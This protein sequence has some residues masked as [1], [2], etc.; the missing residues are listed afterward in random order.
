MQG[1]KGYA[2]TNKQQ[3]I[4]SEQDIAGVDL[5]YISDT[6]NNESLKKVGQKS[7]THC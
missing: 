5:F 2:I 7:Q 4:I 3:L 6:K 1:D